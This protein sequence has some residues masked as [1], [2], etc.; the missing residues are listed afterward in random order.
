MSGGEN[1]PLQR[2]ICS[3]ELKIAIENIDDPNSLRACLGKVP[4]DPYEIVSEDPVM[5]QFQYS[6]R[7]TVSS[8]PAPTVSK[9]PW[10]VS[11]SPTFLLKSSLR[12]NQKPETRN[13]T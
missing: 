10:M 4:L 7:L 5:A 13:E 6:L 8:L 2:K 9:T 11:I 3:G 12:C 1:L